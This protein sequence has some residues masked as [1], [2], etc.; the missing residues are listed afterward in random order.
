MAV[1]AAGLR[2]IPALIVTNRT[3]VSAVIIG[4]FKGPMRRDGVLMDGLVTG[5]LSAASVP[6]PEGIDRAW[7]TG[8]TALPM[9]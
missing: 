7:V 3:I 5:A 2:D 4:I 9:N 6:G 8:F 1:E